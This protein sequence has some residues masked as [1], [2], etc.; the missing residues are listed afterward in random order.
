MNPTPPN[1]ASIDPRPDPEPVICSACR[2]EILM[3]PYNYEGRPYHG[4]CL[5]VTRVEFIQLLARVE[6]LEQK[7]D[8]DLK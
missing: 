7:A 6:K 5:P 2:K 4:H 8:S 3:L 1:N